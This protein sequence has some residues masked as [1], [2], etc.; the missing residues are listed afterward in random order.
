MEKKIRKGFGAG[1]SPAVGVP[2]RRGFP[3]AGGSP[4]P[5]DPAL[6]DP[7]PGDAALGDPAPGDWAPGRIEYSL[8]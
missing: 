1:G 4:A 2:R 6:G 5:G 8:G 3:G 7:A